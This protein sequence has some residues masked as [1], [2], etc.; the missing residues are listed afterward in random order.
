M[1]FKVVAC[2]A[3]L[4]EDNAGHYQTAILDWCVKPPQWHVAD[5]NHLPVPYDTL[6]QT[7]HRNC[8]QRWLCRAD[9]LFQHRAVHPATLDM[10][11][12]IREARV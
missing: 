6:P 8:V 5:D 10:L 2:I 9:R 11:S 1:H 7:F 3:H 12:L 4:G